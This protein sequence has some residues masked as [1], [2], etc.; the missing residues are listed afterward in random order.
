MSQIYKTLYGLF[1]TA[2]FFVVQY[3]SSSLATR[4]KY[5]VVWKTLGAILFI[6]AQFTFGSVESQAANVTCAPSSAFYFSPVLSTS[7]FGRDSTI[8]STTPNYSTELKLHCSGDPDADRDIF[9]QFWHSAAKL[10]PG[11]TNVYPTNLP[12]VGVRYT[13]S[14]GAATRCNGLPATVSGAVLQI[15]CHQMHQAV[16][17]GQIYSLTVSAQ[18]VKLT[19]GVTGPLTTIP[20]LDIRTGINNQGSFT[21]W[22]N[23]FSGDVS[24][25]FTTLT[26]SVTTPS[27][28]VSMAQTTTSQLPS[29]GSSDA[30]TPFNI[31]LDCDPGVKAYMTLTDATAPGNTSNTL[32]LGTDS[33]AA[34]VGYQVLYNDRPI[35]FGADSAAAG[36]L[37]QFS[38]MSSPSEGGAINIPLTARFIR[39]G[40]VTAGTATA[41]ATFTMSYQ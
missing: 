21:D 31:G 39:T 10:I 4:S 12:S 36:N 7:G 1:H 35:S 20:A 19:N 23:L 33:T 11:Y 37:N 27:V 28:A 41:K 32:S 5:R 14:N 24:S 17:P 3:F 16:S 38:A 2:C 18:F 15:T 8:G 25:G 26:C 40:D 6:V 29:V 30:T 13:I 34:G 9:V 22:G